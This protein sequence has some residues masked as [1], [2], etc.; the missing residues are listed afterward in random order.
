MSQQIVGYKLLDAKGS[1]VKEWGGVWNVLPDVPNVIALPGGAYVHCPSLNTDYE[2]C[3][4]V[5]WIMEE[6][7][8]VPPPLPEDIS[9]RQF[10]QQLALMEVITKQEAMDAVRTGT[11]PVALQAII[12][13]L[14]EDVKFAAEMLVSG[15][16]IF[17]RTHP[18]TYALAAG[19]GWTQDQV[20]ALW[21]SAE[22]L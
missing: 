20:D 19:M 3:T 15:A 18:M 2:G 5:E 6:P 4:L 22:Q 8:P 10:F 9:D 7:A 12:D 13:T 16:V 21:V 14:D 17:K 11:I 1:V